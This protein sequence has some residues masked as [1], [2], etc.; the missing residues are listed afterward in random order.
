MRNPNPIQLP[1]R[2]EIRRLTEHDVLHALA[3]MTH[4]RVFHSPLW[5]VLYPEDQ[6]ERAYRL[7]RGMTHFVTIS[8]ASGYS[9]GVFDREYQF[10]RP[11]SAAEGGKLWWDEENPHATKEDLLKQMDFPLVSIAL[12]RA[13][14]DSPWS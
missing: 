11:E 4:S 14:P 3:I 1:A 6:T 10:K 8:C 5:T 13:V 7:Q 2:F 9:Y 12:V